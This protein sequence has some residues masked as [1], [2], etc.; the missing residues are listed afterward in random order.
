MQVYT[1][2]SGSIFPQDSLYIKIT[3]SLYDRRVSFPVSDSDR[4][5]IHMQIGVAS[6]VFRQ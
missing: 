3:V 4:L 5:S 2:Y 6:Q 1:Y